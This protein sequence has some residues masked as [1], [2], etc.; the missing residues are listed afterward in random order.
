[1]SKA[2]SP[3]RD[4]ISACVSCGHRAV[5]H[6]DDDQCVYGEPGAPACPCRRTSDQVI[7]R[8]IFEAMTKAANTYLEASLA[9]PEQMK[10]TKR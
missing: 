7:A 2:A 4:S 3:E 9:T 5:W 6:R 8:L 10:G 1:M